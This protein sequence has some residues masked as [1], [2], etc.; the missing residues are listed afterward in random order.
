MPPRSSGYALPALKVC[1]LI[2]LLVLGI[3]LSG[4]LSNTRDSG[5]P[6]RPSLNPACALIQRKG[7]TR[8]AVYNEACEPLPYGEA[9]ERI[10]NPA[11]TLSIALISTLLEQGAAFFF[12]CAPVSTHTLLS[13]S[14]EFAIVDAPSLVGV[15][16]QP[17]IFPFPQTD[18]PVAAFPNLG[19]DSLLISPLPRGAANYASLFEFIHNA[20]RA[21]SLELFALA[22]RS[23]VSELR[24]GEPRWLS[25]S[26]LGVYWLHVRIDK[27]PK[28]YQTTALKTWPRN[29]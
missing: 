18:K 4:V 28:Y 11:D 20:P 15:R 29:S 27:R 23:F 10:S 24:D 13:S 12:E 16:A 6:V 25:T 5:V 2:V 22:A 9:L 21:D 8:Y 19:G 26:G 3:I 7:A 1:S 14:F 17:G